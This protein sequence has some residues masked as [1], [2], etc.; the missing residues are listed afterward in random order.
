MKV[1]DGFHGSGHRFF[2]ETLLLVDVV[3]Q[4]ERRARS[5]QKPQVPCSIA[6]E[7]DDAAGVRADVDDGNRMWR[8]SRVD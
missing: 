5:S 7:N 4:P 2:A 3:D 8:V 6:F 1:P